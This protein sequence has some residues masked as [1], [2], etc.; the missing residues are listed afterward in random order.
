MSS[1]ETDVPPEGEPP[2]EDVVL[3]VSGKKDSGYVK[4]VAGA[5]GWQMRERGTCRLRA[6]RTDAVYAAVK[7]VATVNHRVSE[8]G[9]LLSINPFFAETDNEEDS[10]ISMSL[11]DVSDLGRPG[12]LVEYR[13]SGRPDADDAIVTRLASAVSARAKKAVVRM[14][15]IGPM[16][17]Y[18]AI[19]AS[20]V[21]KGQVYPNGLEAVVVPT[22]AVA[23]DENGKT[24]LINIDFWCHDI[25]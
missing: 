2:G 5:I 24:S 17:A 16:A 8:A 19:L 15:C 12:H 4:R 22:W 20:T 3:R 25:S 11:K 6:C 1:N 10:A 9:V 23:E 14:R 18:R 13:V 7:A 21:A